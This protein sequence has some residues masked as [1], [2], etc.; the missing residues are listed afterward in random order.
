MR[1][2]SAYR[3]KAN[4]P[5]QLSLKTK[6][7]LIILSKLVI[8]ILWNRFCP[9]QESFDN[10][11][12]K[13]WGVVMVR[14]LRN[15]ENLKICRK[16]FGDYWSDSRRKNNF[17]KHHIKMQYANDK[18]Y[19]SLFPFNFLFYFFLFFI[20]YL[21][22]FFTLYFVFHIFHLLFFTHSF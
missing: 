18:M 20:F 5:L 3:A 15:S 11:I 13:K 17:S 22:L 14:N 2:K 7:L 9:A 4:P 12:S 16:T 1:G 10:I 6:H 19:L 21:F 8:F